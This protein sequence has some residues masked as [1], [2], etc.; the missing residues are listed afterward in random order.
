MQ[1]GMDSGEPVEDVY[2]ALTGEDMHSTHRTGTGGSGN[3]IPHPMGGAS[4]SGV[5]GEG[6]SGNKSRAP[7]QG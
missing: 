6:Y 7:Y 5:R 2:R 4:S 1:D 3:R